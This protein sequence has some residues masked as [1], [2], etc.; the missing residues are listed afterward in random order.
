MVW[1]APHH[2][3]HFFCCVLLPSLL[4]MKKTAMRIPTT[5]PA[6]PLRELSD[7]KISRFIF[8]GIYLK[9]SQ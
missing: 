9:I 8:L 6:V 3:N 7:N 4:I 2:K 1:I 5:N